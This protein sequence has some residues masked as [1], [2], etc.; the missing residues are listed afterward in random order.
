MPK[1][2]MPCRQCGLPLYRWPSQMAVK[3]YGPFCDKDCL[4]LFRTRVLVREKAA[5][6]K[7]GSRK[8]RDYIEVEAIWNPGHN[9]KGYMSLH[10]M[11]AEARM[12]RFLKPDE[13]VHHKDGNARNNH[14]DNLEVMTQIEHAREHTLTRKRDKYGKLQ[15]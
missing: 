12:G 2:K 13:I 15:N 14:W 8:S 11:I 4:G 3:K 6:Y 5:N 7:I 1:E 10:R 9:S